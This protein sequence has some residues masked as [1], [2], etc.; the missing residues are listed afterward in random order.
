MPR[1]EYKTTGV[2]SSKMI[3]ECDDNEVITKVE[4]IGGCPGNTQGVSRLCI[5]KKVDEV[6]ELLSGIKCG[7]RQ[8]SCPDQLSKALRQ[9]KEI[10]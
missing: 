9:L 5:G 10:K 2:C 7:P 6:I 8:T 3:V 1:V 4:I